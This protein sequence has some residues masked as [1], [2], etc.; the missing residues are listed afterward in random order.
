MRITI[1]SIFLINLLTAGIVGLVFQDKFADWQYKQEQERIA[2]IQQ[3]KVEEQK[4]TDFKRFPNLRI[5]GFTRSQTK[6]LVAAYQLGR[7]YDIETR[8]V[9]QAILLQETGA[10]VADRI[11]GLHLPFGL[12]YYGVMQMKV[13][14]VLDVLKNHP[15]F[16]QAFFNKPLSKVST[17][18]IISNLMVNDEFSLTMAYAYYSKYRHRTNDIY[19]A[20]TVY[21]QGPGGLSRIENPEDFDYT[22]SVVR[23]IKYNVRPFNQQLE[24]RF[25]QDN[26]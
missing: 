1:I 16:V 10:G 6:L 2:L 15:K 22:A 18:E 19:E 25:T 5:T 21:N 7:N 23:H 17:E 14:A 8:E 20:I 13:A 9:V 3:Q 11:G 24:K 26:A 4:A 12:R